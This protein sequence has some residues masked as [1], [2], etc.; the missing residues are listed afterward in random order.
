MRAIVAFLLV[1]A[2]NHVAA[3]FHEFPVLKSYRPKNFKDVNVWSAVVFAIDV[4]A[5]LAGE[6]ASSSFSHPQVKERVFEATRRAFWSVF[7]PRCSFQTVAQLT[8]NEERSIVGVS[9]LSYHPLSQNDLLV[10]SSDQTIFMLLDGFHTGFFSKS[11]SQWT[12]SVPLLDR[13]DVIYFNAR[14]VP[15]DETLVKRVIRDHILEPDAVRKARE[16]ARERFLEHTL[17]ARLPASAAPST[18]RIPQLKSYLSP[19]ASSGYT[20]SSLL[21]IMFEDIYATH[22]PKCKDPTTLADRIN[23]TLQGYY[24]LC[25]VNSLHSDCAL[26]N[27]HYFGE[28]FLHSRLRSSRV[29]DFLMGLPCPDSPLS[30]PLPYQLRHLPRN[31]VLLTIFDAQSASIGW[32]D[33]VGEDEQIGLVLELPGAEEM[34]GL[35]CKTTIINVQSLLSKS[36]SR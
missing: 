23:D 11:A 34:W 20:F 3:A 5:R 18:P 1:L 4:S 7:L 19:P 21:K 17:A 2:A 35:A 6:R 32:K 33:V 16:L 25:R 36:K 15:L 28:L 30:F 24:P 12:A 29:R 26:Y 14:D 13:P 9:Q 27:V 31:S 8:H 10:I 22:R